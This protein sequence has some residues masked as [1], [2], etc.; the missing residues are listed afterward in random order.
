M[1]KT[2]KGGRILLELDD[3]NT[4]ELFAKKTKKA[5]TAVDS[6]NKSERTLN[7]NFKGASQQSS[8]TTKN[9]SKMAQGITGGLVPAYATLAAN[10]FAIGA[11]FRFLQ[12][13]ANYR[14]LIEGQKEF[15]TI[16][17]EALSLYTSRL[18]EATGQQLAFAEAAQSVAIARSAGVTTDQ[19]GR[20]GLLAK[21]ASIALGRDLTDSLNRLVRGVTKAEPELLDE[22]GIILRLETAAENYGNK[23]N[24]AGKDLNIFE[25][26]QAVVN[27]VLEQGESKFG[28]F[29]T[30]L[31]AFN[32]LAKSFDDLVNRMKKGLTG[33]A[34]FIAGALSSNVTALAGAFALLGTGIASAISPGM[35]QIDPAAVRKSSAE[36]IGKFY[37]PDSAGG[38]KRLARFQSGTFTAADTKA[39]EKSFAGRTSTVLKFENMTRREAKKTVLILKGYQLEIEA[40]E[41]GRLA[42]G[43]ARFR[44]NLAYMQAEYGGFIGTMKF[45]GS[46]LAAV[47]SFV[48]YAGILIS[49]AG[50]L[51]TFM[52]RF[53]DPAVQK[54]NELQ[55][56]VNKTLKEQLDTLTD[57][58]DGLKQRKNILDQINQTGSFFG[59]FSFRGASSALQFETG[60]ERDA[61]LGET[62]GTDMSG[63]S[64]SGLAG[65]GNQTLSNVIGALQLQIRQLN[66][67]PLS[68]Q[69]TEK[70]VM[71]K[72][73]LT[74]SQAGDLSDTDFAIMLEYIR[75]IEENGT[76]AQK[77]LSKFGNATKLITNSI[78]EFGNAMGKL[79]A[80]STSLS[81]I[82]KSIGDVGEQLSVISDEFASGE[83]KALD[84]AFG[85]D[86]VFGKYA[87]SI[88]TF[89]G[90]DLFDELYDE[91]N[92]GATLKNISQALITESERLRGVEMEMIRA[93]TDHQTKLNG[94]LIGES[95]LRA[96][97]I[98]KEEKITALQIDRNNAQILFNEKTKFGADAT[99]AEIDKL[100]ADL[101][102][103]D[104]KIA[105]AEK[106]ADLLAQVEMTFRNSFEKGMST[107]IQGLI[108]G[109]TNLKDAFLSMTKS[110]LSAMAQILAQQAAI[111]IMGSIPFFPGGG[112]GGREG[113]VMKSPGYRSF[114]T[115]GVSTGPD[116]GYPATLHGTEAVVP[117]PNGKSIPVEMSGGTGGN[118]VTVNVSMVTGESSSTGD[119]ADAYELGRAIST[120]VSNEISKQQRPGGTLSPY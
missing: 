77:R 49:L 21:N 112:L 115:G 70:I 46:Q 42:R 18:Q 20:L 117:L 1:A 26:S 33:V 91:S 75:G 3:G 90:K 85:K 71:L 6:L 25:K 66:D 63:T 56:G 111:A 82:T 81:L 105:L 86:G 47:L 34:E 39:L 35:P 68:Q 94:L 84:K 87:D 38:Q 99:D 107:A 88:K 19:I 36:D 60:E 100:S 2:I 7:R 54:F 16:T 31:N 102:L 32:K 23:I 96:G 13:A 106:E 29:N 61:G 104:S 74:A 119:G 97:Q 4:I 24:K 89:I 11:A 72:N 116:S 53:E 22:L 37:K 64:G 12:D 58:N 120:A 8:N 110:I 27:E 45:L 62:I 80:P 10:V 113:G 109:T 5:K 57:L 103:F 65:K 76:E 114:G 79:R 118:N 15:A 41:K 78:T 59:N 108:E 95:T 48:G 14:I 50:L 55:K 92:Q 83:I 9:F 73:V 51:N 30:E 52:K 69:L 44:A 98:K 101:A 40:S 43:L 67:G 17:G 93:K 28:D